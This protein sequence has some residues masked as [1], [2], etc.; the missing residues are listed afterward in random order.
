MRFQAYIHVAIVLVL[1]TTE[2]WVSR[3][4]RAVHRRDVPVSSWSDDEEP[5]GLPP[6]ILE[7]PC[8][9]DLA[10]VHHHPNGLARIFARRDAEGYWAVRQGAQ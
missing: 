7:P 6:G 9:A 8:T 1:L 4:L 10:A 2:L 3:Q 5:T